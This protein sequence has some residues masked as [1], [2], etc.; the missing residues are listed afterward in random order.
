M[1]S[2]LGSGGCWIDV[3]FSH[4]HSRTHTLATLALPPPLSRFFLS[5]PPVHSFFLS[6]SH[7]P[8]HPLLRGFW[9]KAA[10]SQP[11]I[12]RSGLSVHVRIMVYLSGMYICVYMCI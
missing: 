12:M 4:S 3:S 7:P 5:L 9:R 6:L 11:E 2:N 1:I 10:Q 8:P